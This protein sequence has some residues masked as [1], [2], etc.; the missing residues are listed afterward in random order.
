M[1][2]AIVSDDQD[3]YKPKSSQ[4]AIM[5]QI[6]NDLDT[7]E[8]GA[9]TDYGRLDYNK[10]R[11][12]RYGI[13]ALQA[14]V[15]LWNS[16]YEKCVQS[17]DKV[18]NSAQFGL[19]TTEDTTAGNNDW[20]NS[21]FVTGNSNE[22]IFEFQFNITKS[23]PFFDYFTPNSSNSNLNGKKYLWANYYV[24]GDGG[25]F[26]SINEYQPD[27]RAK[28]SSSFTSDQTIWKWVGLSINGTSVRGKNALSSHWIIYRLADVYLMKAEAL[29]QLDRGQEAK[30]ILE[31]IQN[32]AYAPI[33][34]GS[35]DN[36]DKEGL[37]DLILL[38]RQKEFLFEGKRWFDVLRNARRNKFERM[39]V[40]EN[41]IYNYAPA[42]LQNELIKRFS[43]TL[44][45]Y[46]PIPQAEINANP[47]L[48]Q[49]K[50]YDISNQ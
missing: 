5:K 10:G 36:T 46:F 40:I 16:D 18:I 3:I 50:Y 22:S 25:L 34:T 28:L 42:N 44:S 29:N 39:K 38:E 12:T 2:D 30:D 45:L 7:A 13:N 20:F 31:I 15:Y 41:M 17:C 9:F 23:N 27:L 8:Q 14:D 37:A 24:V 4:S 47:F 6:I 1:L 19:I 11:M 32:R 48:K 35:V 21:L 33:T 43:D 26:S 49:N